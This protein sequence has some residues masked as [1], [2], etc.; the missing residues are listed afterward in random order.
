MFKAQA[1]GRGR[2]LNA[3]EMLRA[4]TEHIEGITL[5]GEAM[6]GTTPEGEDM[7]GTTPEGDNEAR[8]PLASIEVLENQTRVMEKAF[9][10]GSYGLLAHVIFLQDQA[11]KKIPVLDGVPS[12]FF[13]TPMV[14]MLGAIHSDVLKHLIRGD[15]FAVWASSD[16]DAAA[17]VNVR[18]WMAKSWKLSMENGVVTIYVRAHVDRRGLAPSARDYLECIKIIRRYIKTA[19]VDGEPSQGYFDA[20]PEE[21]R[22]AFAIDCVVDGMRK[23]RLERLLHQRNQGLSKTA[24]TIDK[25][26]DTQNWQMSYTERGLRRYALK[27]VGMTVDDTTT[28]KR[29]GTADITKYCDTMEPV[30]DAVVEKNRHLAQT[31]NYVGYTRTMRDRLYDHETHRGSN[32]VMGLV[33]AVFKYMRAKNRVSGTYSMQTAP[34]GVVVSEDAAAFAECALSRIAQC[35]TWMKGGFA[36]KA[37]GSTNSRTSVTSKEWETYEG[38]VVK[39]LGRDDRLKEEAERVK[40][41]RKRLEGMAATEAE[42]QRYETIMAEREEDQHQPGTAQMMRGRLAIAEEMGQRLDYATKVVDFVKNAD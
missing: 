30:F 14:K 24:L 36:G 3:T 15:L 29:E 8:P 6:E 12:Q 40:A 21:V 35:Y 27:D 31:Q 23:R 32:R 20:T 25:T 26:D 4:F 33:E 41:T 34:I 38:L 19:K 42:I 28:L 1:A 22:E 37:A 13:V 9:E 16:S 7:E 5:E 2:P 11:S 18:K 17:D 39:Y 10:F